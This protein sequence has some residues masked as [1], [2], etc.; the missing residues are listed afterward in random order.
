MSKYR[1]AVELVDTSALVAEFEKSLQIN[2][3]THGAKPQHVCVA[4]ALCELERYEEA[5]EKISKSLDILRLNKDLG[6]A[7]DPTSSTVWWEKEIT[8][9]MKKA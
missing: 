2:V 8:N 9:L 1:K 5:Y 3:A 6:A 7:E 4:G